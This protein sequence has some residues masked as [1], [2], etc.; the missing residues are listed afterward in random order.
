MLR[1]KDND[2]HD[3]THTD[4]NVLPSYDKL[5]KQKKSGRKMKRLLM[6]CVVISLFVV[7]GAST[8]TLLR[9]PFDAVGH[10]PSSLLKHLPNTLN[11]ASNEFV[12]RNEPKVDKKMPTSLLSV[13]GPSEEVSE[14][15]GKELNQ[16]KT[17]NFDDLFPSLVNYNHAK[18]PRF[19]VFV[20]LGYLHLWEELHDCTVNAA[21][22][23]KQLDTTI[24]VY[25]TSLDGGDIGEAS[26]IVSQFKLISA[27]NKVEHS[28][29]P[30]RGADVGQFLHQLNHFHFLEAEYDLILKIHTK[31]DSIWRERAL[32]SMCGTREHVHSILREFTDRYSE[33]DMIAPLG[34]KFGPTTPPDEIFN[35]ITRLYGWDGLVS[36]PNE[37]FDRDT[38][39]EMKKYH[40]IFYP[41]SH[42]LYD[43]DLTIVAGTIFWIRVSAL[44]LKQ[45]LS[46]QDEI[47]AGMTSGYRDN[48]GIEHVLE[49]LFPT[50]IVSQGRIIKEI[51]PAPK[52]VAMYF[53]QYHKCE[54]NSKFWGEGFTE[55]T[56]LKP[57]ENESILKPLPVEAGGLGYYDLIADGGITRQRQSDLAMAAG[58]HAF[59]F[60]HYW[61]SGDRAPDHHKVMYK[62][63]EAMLKADE[64][65]IKFM[66]SWANEPWSRRWTGNAG[67]N[68]DDEILLSQEYGEVEEWEEHFN[69]L[70]RFF[71]HKRYLK[72]RGEPVIVIYRAGHIGGKLQ[73]MITKWREMAFAAGFP[74]LHVVNTLGNFYNI[75]ESTGTVLEESNVEASFHFW[76]QLMGSGFQPSIG[77]GSTENFDISTKLQYWGAFSGFDRRPRDPQAI[78]LTRSVKEFSNGVGCSFSCMNDVSREIGTNLYFITAWNEWNEQAV[79]EPSTQHRFGYLQSLHQNLIS[80]PTRLAIN[81]HEVYE[82]LLLPECSFSGSQSDS[83]SHS[84]G[85]AHIIVVVRAYDKQV[86]E[87][88]ALAFS[89]SGMST[90]TCH[91]NCANIIVVPTEV[92]SVEILT[93]TVRLLQRD[94]IPIE[95]VEE[96]GE[97]TW[98]EWFKKAEEDAPSCAEHYTD[99]EFKNGMCEPFKSFDPGCFQGIDTDIKVGLLAEK[100]KKVCGYYNSIH[101]LL[102]DLGLDHGLKRYGDTHNFIMVTNADNA[103]HPSFF[104]KTTSAEKDMVAVHFLTQMTN[105]NF[106]MVKTEF[107]LGQVDLG[108]M[109]FST[110]AVKRTG[111][112]FSNSIPKNI[113]EGTYR[114][115]SKTEKS[116]SLMRCYHDNDWWFVHRGIQDFLVK[117]EVIPM[118]L[119]YHQ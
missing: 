22:A 57:I 41:N 98:D 87:L 112:R 85:N 79:L 115:I 65:N 20:Q 94:G 17:H 44:P 80:F 13:S 83:R 58:V 84:T 99:L 92:N 4:I 61:F 93:D 75:D 10:A 106:R 78:G 82:P 62:V 73:P 31:K 35:H 51:A 12:S 119:F 28:V 6:T 25:I 74:G 116:I 24:D 97:E 19:A 29:V 102:T 72:V 11:Y 39:Q 9:D 110:E 42:T 88:S 86:N 114:H 23:A 103:Y 40:R 100:M 60:Y 91:K 101:Y 64:P 117:G 33:V 76:P 38:V 7:L 63:T 50:N 68:P 56:I 21:A 8:T 89:M 66:L 16:G 52:V 69:Y 36:G 54:E 48:G 70:L 26:S 104:E 105:Q 46:V 27:V 55:W 107:R 15:Q 34:T 49:R 118:V 77:T 30:N 1:K 53:P 14:R 18:L 2:R 109:L 45:M 108:A 47:Y 59:C 90:S 113:L 37:A 95:M 71:K 67:G 32:Q 111:I 96:P 5:G 81:S 43:K 3:V